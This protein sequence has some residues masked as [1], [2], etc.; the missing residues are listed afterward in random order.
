ML[1]GWL[2]GKIYIEVMILFFMTLDEFFRECK[3]KGAT[4][5]SYK[6]FTESINGTKTVEY[7]NPAYRK[8]K[9]VIG[10][11][12]NRGRENNNRIDSLVSNLYGEEVVIHTKDGYHH[13]KLL[14]YDGKA[15]MLGNYLFSNRP[16]ELMDYSTE[17]F[18][19]EDTII[20]AEGIITISKIPIMTE[21]FA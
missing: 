16:M 19:G 18:Y 21:E 10:R 4:P 8:A 6:E 12:L 14:G 1:L 13:G 11:V 15:F 7:E 5:L 17:F 9:E 3:Q 2:L 20:P